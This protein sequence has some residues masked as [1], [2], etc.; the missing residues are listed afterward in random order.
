M[1]LDWTDLLGAELLGFQ[2]ERLIGEGGQ[3]A[4]F[5]GRNALRPD[6]RAALKIVSPLLARDGAFRERFLEEAGTLEHLAH[7]NIVAFRNV[8]SAPALREGQALRGGEQLLVLELELLEGRSL[9]EVAAE[10]ARPNTL[11]VVEWFAQACD[12]LDAAHQRGVVHRDIKPGNLFLTVDGT[13]KVIDFGIARAISRADAASGG[14]VTPTGHTLGT[15]LFIAPEL[16]RGEPASARS[17]LYSLGLSMAQVLL[18]RH[19]FAAAGTQTLSREAVRKGHLEDDLR[20]HLTDH[21]DRLEPGVM[22]MVLWLCAREPGARPA[23]AAM[24]SAELRR[25]RE[26]LRDMPAGAAETQESVTHVVRLVEVS[27]RFTKEA[28]NPGSGS[29]TGMPR[30]AAVSAVAT[31][32]LGIMLIGAVM[33][34]ATREAQTPGDTADSGDAPG[35]APETVTYADIG[36][37]EAE[38]PEGMV[39]IPGGTFEL[40]SV[41]GGEAGEPPGRRVTLSSYWMDRTEVTV[42]AYGE[43]VRAG[44]CRT[45]TT[46]QYYNWGESGREE[47]P[48]NGVSWDDAATYCGWAGKRLPTEAEWE[49]GARGSTNWL[50]PWGNSEP[51]DARLR[52]SGGCGSGGCAGASTAVGSH[53]AGRSPFG[54]E[55]MSGN[56]WEWVADRYAP[57]EGG[58]VTGPSGPS[59]EQHRVVRGGSWS[60]LTP[61]WV[62]SVHRGKHVAGYRGSNVGFRCARGA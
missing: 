42:S 49:Y 25:L 39:S 11:A 8:R 51:S 17:D 1:S 15:P 62:G 56:V 19:P 43:C 9:H 35:G 53:A 57:Y 41:S 40:G 28:R 45:P 20:D 24:A 46:G 10:S 55:D 18:G 27:K 58:E 13:L 12:G 60:D 54:L 2:L 36:T 7:K 33:W 31:A 6:V 3:A 21:R 47:H 34:I 26:E 59:G 48:V 38:E 23:S 50:Y 29:P 22:A 16:W 44:R 4:V 14:C 30:S 61:G 5:E 52:W 37:P 32:A